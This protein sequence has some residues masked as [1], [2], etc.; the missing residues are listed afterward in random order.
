MRSYEACVNSSVYDSEFDVAVDVLRRMPSFIERNM[1]GPS[2]RWA[3]WNETT[4][5]ENFAERWN[6]DP[7]LAAAF[8]EWHTHVVKVLEVLPQAEGMDGITKSLKDVFGKRPAESALEV[9]TKSISQAR[10]DQR[11]FVAPKLGLATAAAAAAV[12]VRA[13][14]FFGA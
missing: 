10:T 1:Q 6:E 9:H 2:V 7:R 3:V 14:T 12:P 13:N 5:G 4:L 11:L 8:F